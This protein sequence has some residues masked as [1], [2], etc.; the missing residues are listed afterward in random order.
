MGKLSSH[1]GEDPSLYRGLR[2]EALALLL[3]LADRTHALS[4]APKPIVVI[5][6]VR[7]DTYQRL[8][9]STNP[10]ADQ[11]YSLHTTG[12]TF[13][14]L[15]RYGSRAQTVAFQYE[16]ERLQARDLIAWTRE[17]KTIHVTVSSEAKTLV[18]AMLQPAQAGRQLAPR[19]RVRRG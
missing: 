2:P 12:Y 10:E 15:R 7:D 17:P 3:H 13:D 8:L 4:G 14:I 11:S 19:S 16:L 9:D 18:E 6:T 1:P 5:S